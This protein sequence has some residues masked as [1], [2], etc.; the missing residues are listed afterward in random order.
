MSLSMVLGTPTTGT[1]SSE[2]QLAAVRV[3]SPPIGM[4]ASMPLSS[5]V[6]LILPSPARST[7]GLVRAVPS[8]VPPLLSSRPSWNP[9]IASP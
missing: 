3:P 8:M 4:S 2:S 5:R 7:S 6:C 9:T 1:P